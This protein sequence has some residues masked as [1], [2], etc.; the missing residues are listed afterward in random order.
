MVA[1]L[2]NQDRQAFIDLCKRNRVSSLFAFGSSVHG[3]FG[4]E[5]DVDVL[6]TVDVADD[7]E[8]GGALINVWNRLEKLFGRPVD[9]LTE[10]SL[11]NPY[12]RKE[13]ER[14]K[15][16]IH[17]GVNAL[18]LVWDQIQGRLPPS[19][20]SSFSPPLMPKSKVRMGKGIM[21]PSLS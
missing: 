19:I 12:L 1:E 13:I 6:V 3:D 7:L 8:H 9:L 15:R 11:K 14:T 16:L 17:D 20:A 2:I 18:V 5:S 21:M 10:N 4:P